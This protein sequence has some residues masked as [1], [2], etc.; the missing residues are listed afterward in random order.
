M[1]A[2]KIFYEFVE[3]PH[4][5]F[6]KLADYRTGENRQYEVKDVA[7]GALELLFQLEPA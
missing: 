6:E 7:L 4:R 5:G 3:E 2:L 1:K